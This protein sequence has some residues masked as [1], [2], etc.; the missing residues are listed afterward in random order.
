MPAFLAEMAKDDVALRE[1]A[2]RGGRAALI[3]YAH[4]MRGKC[5][6]FG[7]G[8]LYG[9]LTRLEEAAPLAPQADIDALISRISERVGELGLYDVREDAA[10]GS[11]R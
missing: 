8:I 6:M 3:E 7:E 10:D 5:A 9:L 1:V 4:A 11:G 2:V